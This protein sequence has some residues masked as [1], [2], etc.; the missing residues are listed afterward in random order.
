ML[1]I[2]SNMNIT[3][4][5][6]ILTL[7]EKIFKTVQNAFIY[8]LKLLRTHIDLSECFFFYLFQIL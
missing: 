5:Y 6:L 3:Q 8:S 1:F 2:N 7:K 4:L